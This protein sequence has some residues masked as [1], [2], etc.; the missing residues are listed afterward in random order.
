M[1]FFALMQKSTISL[2]V[3]FSLGILSWACRRILLRKQ[4]KVNKTKIIFKKF[5]YLLFALMQKV[6]KRSS[7]ARCS[8]GR[9]GQ[10]T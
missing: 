8:A 9:A 5:Y 7:P 2:A 6:A 3:C 4:K 10:R 1:Y